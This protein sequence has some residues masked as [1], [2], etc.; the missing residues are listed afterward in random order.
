MDTCSILYI[1]MIFAI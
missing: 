1:V